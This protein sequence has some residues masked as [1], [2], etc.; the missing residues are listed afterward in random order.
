[1]Q[2]PLVCSLNGTCHCDSQLVTNLQSTHHAPQFTIIVWRVDC[3]PLYGTVRQLLNSMFKKKIKMHC[4]DNVFVEHRAA[5]LLRFLLISGTSKRLT[6][7]KCTIAVWV[8]DASAYRRNTGP[9]LT[10]TLTLSLTLRLF[11][12]PIHPNRFMLYKPPTCAADVLMHLIAPGLIL[13]CT[14][15]RKCLADLQQ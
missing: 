6:Y 9:P 12:N 14:S 1:M 4:S 3:N 8:I 2:L 15:C 13:G 10:L 11:T 5:L 7:S